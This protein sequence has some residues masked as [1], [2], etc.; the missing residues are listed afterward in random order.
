MI[1]A[2]IRNTLRDKKNRKVWKASDFMPEKNTKPKQMTVEES[3]NY[4]ATLN[5]LLGGVDLREFDG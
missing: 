4:V 2:E 1:A 3:V 5:R